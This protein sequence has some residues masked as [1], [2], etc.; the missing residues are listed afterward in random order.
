[1]TALHLAKRFFGSLNPLPPSADDVAWAADNLLEGEV[2]LWN[3]MRRQDRRHS[4]AVA[5]RVDHILDQSAPRE[6]IAAAL[7]H[8]VGKLDSNLGT[9]YRVAATASAR[10]AGHDMAEAWASTSGVTRRI[11][12]YLQHPT[13]GADHLRIAGSHQLTI[14]W[15]EQHH[16]DPETC[17]VPEPYASALREADDD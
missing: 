11:G 17:T 16:N 8:D 10:V 13:I 3:R 7:L 14:A 9:F 4:L 15:T 6:V 5:R 12:L 1:L 2:G